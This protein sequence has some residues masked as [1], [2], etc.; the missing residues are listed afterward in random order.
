MVIR[1]APLLLAVGL[2]F[3]GWFSGFVAVALIL[4]AVLEAPRYVRLRWE[5]SARDFERIADL[6]TV[7]FVSAL[8]FQFLQSRHFPDSLISALV[9]LPMLF[10]ALIL[11]QRYSTAQRVSLSALFWSLRQRTRG[12]IGDRR[13]RQAI[14]LD[15]AY[16]SLCLLAACAANPRTPWFLAGLCV[17]CIYALWPAAP[18][19]T[20]RRAWA[21][22]LAAGLGIGVATQAGLLRAQAGLEELVFDWLSHQW[23]SPSDAYQSRTA[24]GDLGE[25]KASDRIVARVDPGRDPPPQRLRVATYVVYSAATWTAPGQSFLPVTAGSQGWV[26]GSG[27]GIGVH[28][29]AW[30]ERDRPLLALPLGTFRLDSLNVSSVQRNS[31]GAVRIDESSDLLLFDAHFDGSSSLDAPPDAVDLTLPSSMRPT[32]QKVADE[33]GLA[34]PARE[35]RAAAR[36]I[37]AFF[38]SHFTYTLALSGRDG[39]SRSLSQFLLADRRGHCEYFATATVLLLRQAGIPARYATGYAVHEW[40]PLER[41]YVVRKRHAH[42]WALAWID[43]QW[44]ELDTTPAVWTAEERETA[45]L[46]EPLYDLLSLLYY[47]LSLWQHAPADGANPGAI[48]LCIAGALTLYLVWRIWR[49]HRVRVPAAAPASTAAPYERNSRI[50]ALLQALTALG[51]TRPAGTPLLRWVRELP[52]ADEQLRRFLE[53]IVRSY[54]FLRFDPLGTTS[55]QRELLEQR[56]G[57][58]LPHLASSS[59]QHGGDA[60]S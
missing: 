13:A 39:A 14:R 54:Y 49:R 38:D 51:Y 41:Q 16:F 15:Y 31:L 26:F 10:F 17:L 29:S 20:S 47:R 28:I 32:L 50:V 60:A 30:L 11:A 56:V 59:V 27:H 25:L 36:A 58:L 12:E 35:P 3:W 4:A 57:M 9:W 24:I 1:P 37:A 55:E 19:R 23:R 5:L 53:D 34:G 52:L 46:L 42:A 45:P 44:R 8:A 48:M 6:C 18:Q 21:L 43:E 33:I 7:A 22:T 40:S 2:L